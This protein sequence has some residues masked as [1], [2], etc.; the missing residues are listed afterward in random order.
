MAGSEAACRAPIGLYSRRS[1]SRGAHP[2]L[3]AAVD[4]ERLD[5]HFKSEIHLACG[6]AAPNAPILHRGFD[7]HDLYIARGD[8]KRC[9]IPDESLISAALGVERAPGDANGI[10][11]STEQS[12]KVTFV[13]MG[14]A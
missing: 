4:L 7:Q 13:R 1:C 12:V 2:R 6:Y 8:P 9:E 10:F 5:L 14:L 3:R 11:C